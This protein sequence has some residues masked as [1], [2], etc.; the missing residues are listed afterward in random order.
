[1][2]TLTLIF[3]VIIWGIHSNALWGAE[4]GSGSRDWKRVVDLRG[5]W[6]FELGDDLQWSEPSFDDSDWETIFAPSAWEDEGYPGYDGYAWYRN[7]F[8]ISSKVDENRLYLHLGHVDDVDEVYLNGQFIGFGGSFPPDYITGFYMDRQYVI[9]PGILNF[10]GENTL[11]VRVYDES[12]DGGIVYGKIGIFEK[13]NNPYLEINLSGIWKFSTSDHEDFQSPEYDDRDWDEVSAPAFWET[14]GYK[15]YDG[16]G[17]YRSKFEITTDLVEER[18]VL[19][20]GKIDDFDE[21]YLNGERIGRTGRI[22]NWID[23]DDLGNKYLKLRAYHIPRNI[24]NPE[25]EN[26]I[27]VRVYD[28]WIHGG[29]YDGPIGITT[30]S[31]DRKWEKE[32]LNFVDLFNFLWR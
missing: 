31:E 3:L 17:W 30:R 23:H 16:I 11:A 13:M 7:R 10:E 25:G 1:M 20:L 5:D 15:G 28:G 9:P 21:V 27:A 29:I 18:L 22:R 14:Q 6:L 4:S 2:K 8:N 24:L 19:L 26:T 12:I 32:N